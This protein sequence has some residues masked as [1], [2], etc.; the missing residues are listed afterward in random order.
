MTMLLFGAL[1]FLIAVTGSAIF[2]E[3]GLAILG[4]L[5]GLT[6]YLIYPLLLLFIER[7]ICLAFGKKLVAKKWFWIATLLL[8]S[9]FAI[10]HLAMTDGFFAAENGGTVGYGEYLG[11]CYA[12]GASGGTAGGILL[13]LVVYLVRITLSSAG[14]YVLYSLLILLSVFLVLRNLPVWGKIS[15]KVTSSVRK[16]EQK[17]AEADADPIGFDSIPV[18]SRP[19][20]ATRE[21]APARSFFSGFVRR[22]EDVKNQAPA[23]RPETA[24]ATPD[25]RYAPPASPRYPAYGGTP[26]ENAPSDYAPPRTDTPRT[27]EAMPDI[28][29]YDPR[30]NYRDNL[31]FSKDSAFNNPQRIAAMTETPKP[32]GPAKGAS[33]GTSYLGGYT[34]EAEAP[35]TGMPKRVAPVPQSGD[36][37]SAPYSSEIRRPSFMLP[38]S[39]QPQKT[40]PKPQDADTADKGSYMRFFGGSGYTSPPSAP[41]RPASTEPLRSASP[42][43]DPFYVTPTAASSPSSSIGR[44]DEPFGGDEDDPATPLYGSQD[45]Q[46]QAPTP[47]YPAEYDSDAFS[48]GDDPE[49]ESD[50]MSDDLLPDEAD[51]APRMRSSDP[52]VSDPYT[53]DD[54]P[55]ASVDRYDPAPYSLDDE[56]DGGFG[57]EV[58][59]DRAERA[60][61][62]FSEEFDDDLSDEPEAFGEDF[63]EDPSEVKEEPKHIPPKRIVKPYVYPTMEGLKQYAQAKGLSREEIEA[64]INT[65]VKTLESFKVD[66]KVV[67]VIQGASVT[68]YDVDIP[69]NIP[70]R[71]VIRH[72]AEIG[73]R[74]QA[75]KG[76]N[77]YSNSSAGVISIEV[78]NKERAIVGV[79]EFLKQ[80]E[81]VNAKQGSLMFVM[82]QSLE[83]KMVFGD[84]VDMTHIL[85]A[86]T[87]GA[88]KS[89]CLNSMLISL[90]S[91]YSPEELRLILIDPKRVEFAAYDGIPHLIVNEIIS[92]PQK[93]LTAFNWAVE[94]MDRRYLLFEQKT[95]AGTIVSS[96]DEYN[97]ALVEG[98]ERMPKIVIII[99]EFAELMLSYPKDM[100]SRIQRL[101]QKARAAG[102][103]LVIATQRPSVN[104][105]TGV[106][107]SNLP[108]RI[109]FR[110]I[111]E[112]DS[113]I[114]LD[115]Q[116]AEKLLG[117]GDM[118]YRTSD[119]FECRRIQGA[120]IDKLEVQSVIK[121][122][123]ENNE[124]RF[125]ST[126]SDYI[127]QP[128]SS[129]ESGASADDKDKKID[130]QYLKALR[131]V[132]SLGSAS[133]SLIQRKC[134]VGYAHAG[135]IFDWMEEM[136]YVEPFDGKAKARTVLLTKEEF[137]SKYG[138]L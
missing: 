37:G 14:S 18:R 89:S 46:T 5:Y 40:E 32:A 6:G 90:I 109:A 71:A 1:V 47:Y 20:E 51:A 3:M 48:A 126:V 74:L 59:S 116:G 101:S 16:T 8:C 21:E 94:E 118:L 108:T 121:E 117:K 11:A 91:R 115:S 19:A 61:K 84:I 50:E 9:V 72:Q 132:V 67:D 22:S 13:G 38:E 130:P 66:A 55:A 28:L 26:A 17:D 83:G 88:G 57:E 107:K 54:E 62:S 95:V 65:I 34:S 85:V 114:V 111:Q 128:E 43:A 78:P 45:G 36:V 104:V 97:G 99:D 64:N 24:S 10:A 77:I 68:R 29:S 73:M 131:I 123:K 44:T 138:K 39:E 112:N 76:V 92:D 100:E 80:P 49:T 119:M 120:Y 102:I 103:H 75:P 31:I 2:G 106:I 79:K 41:I 25:I 124:P 81:F 70:N 98:E 7:G 12:A 30:A 82:G 4:F 15:Q 42:S 86:G 56:T 33:G 125:D 133:I 122:I 53:L 60:M 113:R 52:Y 127:N 27:G 23:S 110:V 93:A 35:R 63:D 58:A 96:I 134:S 87:T 105:I 137:E 129:S 136:G 69:T 135:K